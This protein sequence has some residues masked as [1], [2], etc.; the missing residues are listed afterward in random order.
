M[1][2]VF[3]LLV[4][5]H[6]IPI[7]PARE[8]TYRNEQKQKTGDIGKERQVQLRERK[9]FGITARNIQDNPPEKSHSFVL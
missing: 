4:M 7:D 8:K 9:K 2:E 6:T 3:K 1:V 5:G